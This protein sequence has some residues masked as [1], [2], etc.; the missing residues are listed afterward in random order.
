MADDEREFLRSIFL[1]EAWD[2]VGAIE[3]EFQKLHVAPRPRMPRKHPLLMLTHT[4]RGSAAVQGFV[5]I[6]DLA[7][8]MEARL[9]GVI[10][11][12]ARV[13]RAQLPELEAAL[14]A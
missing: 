5:A 7:A 10:G 8:G 4:V 6:A 9:E 11:G 1:M 12:G 3:D 13:I 2:V 14:A